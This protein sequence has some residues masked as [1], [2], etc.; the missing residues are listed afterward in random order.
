M[1]W[2]TRGGLKKKDLY[3]QDGVVWGN[4]HGAGLSALFYGQKFFRKYSHLVN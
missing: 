4:G 2:K 1:S 3:D